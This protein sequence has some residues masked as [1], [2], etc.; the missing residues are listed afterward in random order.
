MTTSRSEF[1]ALFQ[2]VSDAIAFEQHVLSTVEES[3]VTDA[4][5]AEIQAVREGEEPSPAYWEFLGAQ[6]VNEPD[7]EN[8]I[9]A[10]WRSVAKGLSDD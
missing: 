6:V 4:L 8:A 1:L 2:S 10:G 9:R 7:D 5:W 3:F